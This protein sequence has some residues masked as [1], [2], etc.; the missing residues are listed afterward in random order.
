M[1]KQRTKL[2]GAKEDKGVSSTKEKTWENQKGTLSKLQT[3][4][5]RI[6][7]QNMIEVWNIVKIKSTWCLVK[8]IKIIIRYWGLHPP[9]QENKFMLS[10]RY[11]IIENT[12][13]M[14]S[15]SWN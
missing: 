6:I 8:I 11:L 15:L 1:T 4:I 3:Y 13:Q 9:T 5:V 12:I 2:D 7:G 14:K 10:T